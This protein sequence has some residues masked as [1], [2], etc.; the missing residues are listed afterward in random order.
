MRRAFARA[1]LVLA[2]IAGAPLAAQPVGQPIA[3]GTSYRLESKVLNEAREINI[4]LPASYASADKPRSYP[5]LYLLDG[6]TDQ[7]FAHIAGLAQHGEVSWTFDEFIVVGIATRKRIWELTP[8]TRD[9]RYTTYLRANGEPVEFA[10]GGGA[11]SLRRFIAE[12]VEPFVRANFRTN[13]KRTLVGE[14]L[15][16]LFIIDTLLKA[17]AIADDFIAISPSLWWNREE[18]GDRAAPLLKS[19]DYAG[20]RFY[21]TMAD[22]GG[23]MQRGLDKLLAALRSPAAGALRWVYVDRRNSEHHGSIYHAAALDALRTLYPKPYRPGSPLPWLHVGG[24][25]PLSAAAEA[26]RKLECTTERA[27]PVTFAEINAE[28]DRWAALCTLPALG[29]A[30]E[31]REASKNWGDRATR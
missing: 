15:A 18:L 29:Q 27:R 28:P 26:D 21:V 23:T 30:P 1:A 22:E 9:E 11:D 3:L 5:V 25:R 31:P 17:P 13:G 14:S 19:Q 2:L 7:D 6:G 8:P 20:K 4:R 24:V 12:E 10:N 16:A